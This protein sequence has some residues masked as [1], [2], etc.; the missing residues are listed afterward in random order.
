MI[1]LILGLSSLSFLLILH[2]YYYEDSRD[3]EI[4][5]L[6]TKIFA[7]ETELISNLE[8]HRRADGQIIALRKAVEELRVPP[9]LQPAPKGGGRGALIKDAPK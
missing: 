8:A 3:S 5:R 4:S 7:Y 6:R 2:A 9:V 1:Y